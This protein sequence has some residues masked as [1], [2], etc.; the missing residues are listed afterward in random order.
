MDVTRVA[1]V[2]LVAPGAGE[3]AGIGGPTII[4]DFGRGTRHLLL[5]FLASLV[6]ARLGGFAASCLI[7]RRIEL[8]R[9]T[10][11]LTRAIVLAFQHRIFQQI[12]LDFLL[13]F[14]GRQLQELDR[15]LQLRRQ[16]QMLG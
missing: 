11:R 7:G 1:V 4:V 13:H 16:G 6:F 15:L 5:T 10:E 12:T 14:D 2:V 8:L 9:R 3:G